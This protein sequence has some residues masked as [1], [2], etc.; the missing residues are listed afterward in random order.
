MR[1]PF[2]IIAAWL[3]FAL[4][5]APVAGQARP[6]PTLDLSAGWTGFVD[7]AWIH[8]GTVGASTRF[9]L[10]PRFSIGPEVTYMV[11]PD[12]DRDLFVF[13]NASYEW[14]LLIQAGYPRLAPY[15]LGGCGYM[16]HRSPYIVYVAHSTAYAGGAGVRV[17]LGD[18]L[19][20]APE[21]RLGS[22]LDVRMSGVVSIRLGDP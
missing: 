14:P 22:E 13:G 15:V 2:A 12:T 16:R 21:F 3:A 20:V 9:Y 1:A 6:A 17:G 4:T 5:A 7:E 10:T 19:S 11:G 18:R 8:H